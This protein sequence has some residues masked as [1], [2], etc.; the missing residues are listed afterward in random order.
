M[1]LYKSP[2]VII[3]IFKD[4]AEWHKDINDFGWGPDW[5]ITDMKYPYLWTNIETTDI[6]R[7]ENNWRTIEYSVN[8][9]L[10]DR[11]NRFLDGVGKG[12]LNHS[13]N[14]II[15]D[16][17]TTLLEII[18]LLSKHP[19]YKELNIQLWGDVSVQS[20]F[21]I[22][23][24]E[25]NGIQTT[26]TLRSV[27]D[28]GYCAAPWSISPTQSIWQGS[29]P[30]Y[31]FCELISQCSFITIIENDIFNLTN[32]V[33]GFSQSII[34]LENDVNYLMGLTGSYMPLLG[35]NLGG[36]T[37]SLTGGDIILNTALVNISG[38]LNV[39]GAVILNQ[40]IATASATHSLDWNT[41]NN[42][43]YTI[44]DNTTFNFINDV[45]GQTIV[46]SFINTGSFTIGF[47]NTI[48]W[49]GGAPTFTTMGTDVA[50][51]IKINGSI[52]GSVI[53]NF[54]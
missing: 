26:I 7:G 50:T 29:E 20:E 39:G 32:T 28:S 6:I 8:I 22:E 34:D 43:E 54:T 33:N 11:V 44:T 21:N 52:Y 10:R 15:S 36:E 51:F 48:L 13:G 47:S 27:Y 25:E 1:S 24:G 41:S 42:F 19:L 31:N 9:K 16:Q 40:E 18:Q 3:K 45:D 23:R 2:N 46:V 49:S 30:K 17:T 53:Q 12:E 35:T 37:F 14:D 38:N 4:I 5:E